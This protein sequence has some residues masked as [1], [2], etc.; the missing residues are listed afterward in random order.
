[1]SCF[2]GRQKLHPPYLYT[3]PVS[4]HQWRFDNTDIHTDCHVFAD[5]LRRAYSSDSATDVMLVGRRAYRA[6]DAQHRKDDISLQYVKIP[7]HHA[8]LLWHLHQNLKRRNMHFWCC[9]GLFN[10]VVN[11]P[12]FLIGQ[13]STSLI[14]WLCTKQMTISHFV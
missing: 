5:I 7:G 8:A 14:I 12:N 13:V 2:Q 9:S 3:V 1:M 6:S 11:L 4:A 10:W